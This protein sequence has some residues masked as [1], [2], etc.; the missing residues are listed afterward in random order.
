MVKA[1]GAAESVRVV[2]RCRPLNDVEIRDGRMNC[3]SMEPS[4]G[5]VVLRNPKD[6]SE[7]EPRRF[8]FDK[9]FAEKVRA[10]MLACVLPQCF[11]SN[12]QLNL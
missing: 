4:R 8:T 10:H 6:P 2:V 12:P 9:V 1:S 7:T 3:V 5:E 11:P